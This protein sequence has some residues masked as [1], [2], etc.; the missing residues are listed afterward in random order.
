MHSPAEVLVSSQNKPATPGVAMIGVAMVDLLNYRSSKNTNWINGDA[1][2]L[3]RPL[4][5]VRP[6]GLTPN[7]RDCSGNTPPCSRDAGSRFI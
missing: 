2:N 4:N 1:A 5:L 3:T 7:D 6:V